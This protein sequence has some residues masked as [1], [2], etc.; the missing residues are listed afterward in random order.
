MINNPFV[1][2]VLADS[3]LKR[4]KACIPRRIKR[5]MLL[6]V[7]GVDMRPGIHPSRKWLENDVL[8]VLPGLGFRRILFVGTAPYTWHYERIACRAGG[9]WITCDVN[10]SAAVW[11]ARRHAVA[12]VQEIDARF[13]PGYFDAVILSG[14]LAFGIDPGA[15]FDAA[16][17]AISRVLR[18]E[19]LLLLGWNSDLAADPLLSG[20]MCRLFRAAVN[21]PLPSRRSFDEEAFVYDFQL[22]AEDHEQS[23]SLSG[24]SNQK[25]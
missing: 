2:T 16:I 12:R 15:D 14:V 22:R 3:Q 23:R 25:S 1:S 5:F 13:A 6:Y 8:A 9:E 10:P 17:S 24:T 20:G 21:L 19:G 18:P 11:G 4:I 7:F